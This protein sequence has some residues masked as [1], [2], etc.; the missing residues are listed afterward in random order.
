ITIQK[1]V[2]PW[3]RA[4]KELLAAQKMEQWLQSQANDTRHRALMDMMGGVL[5][6][7]K[8]DILRMVIPQPAFMAKPDAI[9]TEEERKQFKDYEKKVRELNEERDKYRKSLEA[10]LRKLQNSIQE[11]TQNFDE[12]LKR[13]FERR[14][15]AE[16][17]INQ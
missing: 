15:K 12:Y 10:E 5:E 11:S 14:V 1:H 6:V 16:M 8:E 7:K 4:K 17:V 2:P 9:W 3:Q 13:L